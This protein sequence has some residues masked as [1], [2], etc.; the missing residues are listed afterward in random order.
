MS[1]VTLSTMREIDVYKLA[2]DYKYKILDYYNK[3]LI[4]EPSLIT[5][6]INPWF[7]KELNILI[8]NLS[9]LLRSLSRRSLSS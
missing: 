7:N 9:N 6:V 5:L 3:L 1:H 8:K 2:S 4:N